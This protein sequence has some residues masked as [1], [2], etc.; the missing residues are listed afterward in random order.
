MSLSYGSVI[1]PIFD[2]GKKCFS[3]H[4]LYC[5]TKK[6]IPKIHL[7][8]LKNTVNTLHILDHVRYCLS[9]L[10]VATIVDKSVRALVVYDRVKTRNFRRYRTR[11]NVK[12]MG[13]RKKLQ[14]RSE[15]VKR[16]FQRFEKIGSLDNLD[17]LNYVDFTIRIENE[18]M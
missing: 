3:E 16:R 10:E 13:S 17:P 8:P 1:I 14:M 18:P 9:R 2:T 12:L 6:T 5:F 15:R 11:S 7:L 4:C